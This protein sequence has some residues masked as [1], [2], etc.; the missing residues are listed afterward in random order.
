MHQSFFYCILDKRS[1]FKLSRYNEEEK[2]IFSLSKN[3]KNFE[4]LQSERGTLHDL[5]L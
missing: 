5:S 3:D 1:R 2:S 4:I